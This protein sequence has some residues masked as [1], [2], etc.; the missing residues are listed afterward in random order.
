MSMTSRTISV[1]NQDLAT[2]RSSLLVHTHN[3]QFAR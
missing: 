2:D 1:I 3:S